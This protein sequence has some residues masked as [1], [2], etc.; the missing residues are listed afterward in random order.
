MKIKPL[1]SVGDKSEKRQEKKRVESTQ[2][3]IPNTGSLKSVSSMLVKRD[4]LKQM[5]PT[6]KATTCQK[7]LHHKFRMNNPK[8]KMAQITKGQ[9]IKEEYGE[10][11]ERRRKRE[12]KGK[13]KQNRSRKKKSL[14][15]AATCTCHVLYI[16]REI[17]KNKHKRQ[18]QCFY[19]T[20]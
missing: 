1:D 2:N 14:T 12:R 11:G 9:Q 19:V 10:W 20:F 15:W 7:H 5:Y 17:F 8:Q 3:T 4:D 13:T 6:W 18:F 16:N